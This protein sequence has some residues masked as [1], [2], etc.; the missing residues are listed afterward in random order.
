MKNTIAFPN[1]KR[2]ITLAFAILTMFFAITLVVGSIVLFMSSQNFNKD[3][4]QSSTVTIQS[5]TINENTINLSTT[6][7]N[8]EIKPIISQTTQFDKVKQLEDAQVVIYYINTEIFGIVEQSNMVLGAEQMITLRHDALTNVAVGFVIVGASVLVVGIVA[9]IFALKQPKEVQDDILKAFYNLGFTT[10]SRRKY[11][12][13]TLLSL[14][15]VCIPLVLA[16]IE[17]GKNGDETLKFNILFFGFLTLFVTWCVT[18]LC[19]LPVIR[20]KDIEFTDEAYELDNFISGKEENLALDIQN[21][22]IFSMQKNGLNCEFEK[23]LELE[24]LHFE[25]LADSGGYYNSP[26]RSDYIE[27]LKKEYLTMLNSTWQQKFLEYNLLNLY[28]RLICRPTGI[29]SA[30]IFSEL[31]EN[32]PFGLKKDIMIELNPI[33]YHFFKKSNAKI[34]GLEQF[35]KNRKQ[36]MLEKCK[37]KYKI[38]DLKD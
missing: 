21:E 3:K 26:K 18:I 2:H 5:V 20:K 28:V 15:P 36:I 10:D 19:F 11:V 30:Y 12:K 6:I 17:N 13:W 27:A 32:N 34:R 35:L 23:V 29:V 33:T 37:G 31:D 4:L 24:Q 25:Y 16:L 9:L 22:M 7:G 8:F 1:K 38:L 14:I